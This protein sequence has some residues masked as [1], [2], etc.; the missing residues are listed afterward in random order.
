MTLELGNDG[1]YNYCRATHKM[2]NRATDALSACYQ[3]KVLHTLVRPTTILFPSGNAAVNTALT[4]AVKLFKE[5]YLVCDTVLYNDTKRGISFIETMYP[6]LTVVRT[7]LSNVHETEKVLDDLKGKSV[8]L[9]AETCTNPEGNH[10]DSRILRKMTTRKNKV[11]HVVL[12]NSMRTHVRCNPFT[13]FATIDRSKVSVAISCSKHIS[14]GSCVAGAVFTFSSKLVNKVYSLCS[15]RGYH[16]SPETCQHLLDAIPSIRERCRASSVLCG[17]L[18]K[19]LMTRP[20][21]NTVV[22]HHAATLDP[23]SITVR[24]SHS[25]SDVLNL[26]VTVPEGHNVTREAVHKAVLE[27]NTFQLATSYG[28]KNTRVCNYVDIGP[29]HYCIRVSCGYGIGTWLR[30]LK[31]HKELANIVAAIGSGPKQ[32]E[33]VRKTEEPKKTHGSETGE[34]K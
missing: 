27:S 24:S 16:V 26:R 9:F 14:A 12:D 25:F 18:V 3:M 34:E 29:T 8:V 21:P 31:L 22:Q 28:G 1:L 33:R 19:R 4:A 30:A 10:I 15:W 6:R 17:D 13:A 2:Y 23:K 5:P 11:W 32:V 7:N 20:I